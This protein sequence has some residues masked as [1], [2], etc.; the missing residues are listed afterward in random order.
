MTAIQALG[1]GVPLSRIG[2][3]IHDVLHN[4]RYAGRFTLV[5]D[6]SGHFIG[7][8]MH[9]PPLVSHGRAASADAAGVVMLREGDIFTVEPIVTE[10]NG[11]LKTW[12]DGWTM[13]SK[14]NGWCAQW[15]HTLLITKHGAEILTQL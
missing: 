1:P 7:T 9:M 10:G 8:Q 4:E 15:E 14:D 5:E 6:F 3:T 12:R 13:V 11:R 2:D